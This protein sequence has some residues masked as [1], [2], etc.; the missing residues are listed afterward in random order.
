[1]AD[2]QCFSIIPGVSQQTFLILGMVSREVSGFLIWVWFGLISTQNIIL[3]TLCI[4]FPY[5]PFSMLWEKILPKTEMLWALENF[6]FFFFAVY[7]EGGVLLGL[8]CEIHGTTCMKYLRLWGDM[9]NSWR[10]KIRGGG[11]GEDSY[12][13][14]Q[15]SHLL[16]ATPR[17]EV[18][19][20]A[21]KESWFMNL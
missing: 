18:W 15:W 4:S 8:T 11:G 6:F 16:K 20:R 2:L 13:F 21:G 12:F 14:I 5:F 9:S 3:T 19:G 7:M 10:K 17:Y 1:M